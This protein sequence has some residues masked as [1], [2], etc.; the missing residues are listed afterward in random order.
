MDFRCPNCPG[1]HI[2]TLYDYNKHRKF[3]HGGDL[4]CFIEECQR[5]GFKNL[6]QHLFE[7]HPSFGMLTAQGRKCSTTN[8]G[9]SG[10]DQQQVLQH[11]EHEESCFTAAPDDE[12]QEDTDGDECDYSDIATDPHLNPEQQDPNAVVISIFSRM[13][14]VKEEK[15]INDK[16]FITLITNTLDAIR[17]IMTM[18]QREYV[19]EQLME[20]M[21]NPWSIRSFIKSQFSFVQ[22]IS[23]IISGNECY[24]IPIES[25]LRRKLMNIDIAET[26]L[27]ANSYLPPCDH[28]I[29]TFRDTAS[30][31]QDSKILFSKYQGR[32]DVLLVFGELYADDFCLANPVGPFKGSST[33]TGVYMNLMDVHKKDRSRR[34]DQS[35]VSIIPTGDCGLNHTYTK[36]KDELVQLETEGFNARIAGKDYLV[37]FLLCKVCGDNKSIF[38]LLGKSVCFSSGSICRMCTATHHQI[39]S[40]PFAGQLRD[41]FSWDEDIKKF[42]SGE[43]VEGMRETPVFAG[44]KYF[45]TWNLYPQDRLH[46]LL[47]GVYPDFMELLLQDIV[48][49]SNID[50]FNQ[51]VSKIQ[52]KNGNPEIRICVGGRNARSLKG[53]G[54]QMYDLFLNLPEILSGFVFNSND[55]ITEDQSERWERIVSGI[56]YKTFLILRRFDCLIRQESFKQDDLVAIN[57][58]IKTFFH[59]RS[60]FAQSQQITPKLHLHDPLGSGNSHSWTTNQL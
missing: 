8:N 9:Q 38:E 1:Y 58:L 26:L 5:A 45:K 11:G 3:Y 35:L 49:P 29:S 24:R 18:S 2:T 40:D 59:Q 22:P 41:R 47:L 54:S 16:Q 55:F 12:N 31:K 53:S 44:L 20:K 42:L 50:L 15:M 23:H 19:V 14:E 25:I 36:I 43:N 56:K 7:V 48:T 46:T 51:A 32:E 60:Q 30:F 28:S 27:N 34:E 33:V 37:I 4:V 10:N 21:K 6:R 17:S 13:M 52:M 57:L 39:Q